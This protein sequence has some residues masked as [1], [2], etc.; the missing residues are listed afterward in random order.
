MFGILELELGVGGELAWR[1]MALSLHSWR[2]ALQAVFLKVLV[3]TQQEQQW[4]TQVWIFSNN[5]KGTMLSR[6]K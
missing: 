3:P 4:E 5:V 2:G 1:A 6:I